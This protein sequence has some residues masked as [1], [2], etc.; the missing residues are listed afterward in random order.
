[1]ASSG[2]R[3][4]VESMKRGEEVHLTLSSGY[5]E[6]LGPWVPSSGGVVLDL[7]LNKFRRVEQVPDTDTCV[8]KKVMEEGEG[9][10]RPNDGASVVATVV[11]RVLDSGTEFFRAEPHT[12]TVDEEE[13]PDGVD[14]TLLQMKKGEH[15]IVTITDG[16]RFGL[17]DVETT[18]ASGVTVP[19]GAALQYDITLESFTKTK[20]SWDMSNEEK[21]DAALAKKEAGNAYFKAGKNARAMKRYEQGVKYVEYDGQF[22]DDLKD[23]IKAIKLA[24]FSNS[25]AACLKLKRFKDAVTNANKALEIDPVHQKALF[26]RAQ[27]YSGLDD[28]EEAELDLKKL[29]EMDSGNRDARAELKRLR[30]KQAM[31]MKKDSAIFGNMFDRMRKAGGDMYDAPA[32]PPGAD[33]ASADADAPPEPVDGA[34]P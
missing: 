22:P 11:G 20:E 21:I 5:A 15:A 12:W 34:F 3:K 8:E 27:A 29:I 17:G 19:P 18:S 10:E 7:A 16:A 30:A 13:M 4:C 24:V 2:L 33:G 26:R 23:Q 6:G 25:A 1:M 14:R 32:Q 28:H 9:Y 31:Q